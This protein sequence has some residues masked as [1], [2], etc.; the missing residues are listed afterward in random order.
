MGKVDEHTPP[1]RKYEEV[2]NYLETVFQSKSN[3]QFSEIPVEYSWYI[4]IND[5]EIDLWLDSR[6]WNLLGR[7]IKGKIAKVRPD[8]S[9]IHLNELHNFVDQSRSL[10]NEGASHMHKTMH[11]MNVN[12]NRVYLRSTTIFH[13]DENNHLIGLLGIGDN[14]SEEFELLK[15]IAENNLSAKIGYWSVD[16]LGERVYWDRVTCAIHGESIDFIPSIDIGVSYYKEGKNRE[17]LVKHL[18][19]LLTNGTS[20]DDEFILVHRDGKEVWVRVIARCT[21]NNGAPAKLHGIIQDITEIKQSKRASQKLA[22]LQ[23]KS[24]ELEQFA[25]ITSHDLREPLITVQTYTEILRDEYLQDAGEEAQFIAQRSLETIKR[26]DLLI[27]D[28]LQ[29]SKTS[30]VEEFEKISLED[31]LDSAICNLNSRIESTNTT[32]HREPLPEIE[33]H[34]PK[35]ILLFQNILS[36]A[37]KFSKPESSPKIEISCTSDHNHYHIRFKDYGLGIDEDSLKDVFLIFRRANTGADVEG[38]GIGLAICKKIAELHSGEISVESEAGAFT[39]FTIT[40][41]RSNF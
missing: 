23:S 37:I 28:L 40:L 26:L 30:Q 17:R 5:D 39:E 25:Y 15:I 20:Y 16:L 34:Q 24:E 14:I 12:G 4:A 2:L 41:P 18:E 3:G 6:L 33:G 36:N 1:K 21:W 7:N 29:Y 22:A 10:H 32:I 19:E 9:I 38:T 35:I 8:E 11:L 31:C 13:L 27:R